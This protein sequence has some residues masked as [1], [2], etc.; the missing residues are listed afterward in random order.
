LSS[1]G[2]NLLRIVVVVEGYSST[3]LLG[4]D[5]SIDLAT[6]ILGAANDRDEAFVPAGHRFEVADDSLGAVV[7]MAHDIFSEV[8]APS[9][10]LDAVNEENV[11]SIEDEVVYAAGWIRNFS[12]GILV[13]GKSPLAVD[14]DGMALSDRQP[15][16][17]DKQRLVG[18]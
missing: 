17:K 15:T 5:E 12:C 2:N 14:S 4:S 7:G 1:C 9:D 8:V 11:A 16:G 18:A 10:A 13:N 3:C 6:V